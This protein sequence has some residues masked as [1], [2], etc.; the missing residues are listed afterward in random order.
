MMMT[1]ANDHLFRQQLHSQEKET[2]IFRPKTLDVITVQATQMDLNHDQC[3]QV[4][5]YLND[6]FSSQNH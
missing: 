3:G 5:S 6:V 1:S 4:L 2:L